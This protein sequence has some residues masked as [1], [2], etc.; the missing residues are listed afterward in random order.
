MS[1][2]SNSSPPALVRQAARHLLGEERV[3]AGALGDRGDRAGCPRCR[4]RPATSTSSRVC[5]TVSGSSRIEV[6]SW[7]PPP[8]RCRRSISSSRARHSRISGPR[9][10]C[11]RYSIRSSIPWSAQWMSSKTSTSGLR[12]AIASITDRTAEKNTSRMRCGSSLSDCEMLERR[13]DA[14]QPPD[15]GGPALGRLGHAR[16]RSPSS[17]STEASSF[18]QASSV[19]SP[20]RMPASA[21]ITSASAQYTIPEPYGRQRP[22]RKV[23]GGWRCAEQALQLLA[24]ARLADAGLADHGHQVRAALALDAVVDGAQQLEL[25]RAAHQRGLAQARAARAAAAP[26]RRPPPTQARARPCPSA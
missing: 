6:A 25:V 9:T 1:G 22:S 21:R 7:R 13:L 12:R 24:Q 3:A 16:R 15:H 14:E 10:H 5:S 8:H 26:G 2:S 23:G 18:A 11:V 4:A 17:D 20:S 19:L